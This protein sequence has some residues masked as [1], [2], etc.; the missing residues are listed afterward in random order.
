MIAFTIFAGSIDLFKYLTRK[1][2]LECTLIKVIKRTK[3]PKTLIFKL[4]GLILSKH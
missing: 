4:L 3:A 2:N 1:F